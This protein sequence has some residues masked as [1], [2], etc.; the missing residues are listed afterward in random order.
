[1]KKVILVVT[2]LVG[3][4]ITSITSQAALEWTL[5][6]CKQHWG[7]PIDKHQISGAGRMAYLFA[8]KGYQIAVYFRNS[9]VCRVAY[10]RD[11]ALDPATIDGLLSSNAPEATWS[12]PFKDVAEG[13][14]RFNGQVNGEFCYSAVATPQYLVIWNKKDD[15][16]VRAE[17]EKQDKDL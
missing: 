3:L 1:M 6:E 14:Y 9:K 12:P 15:D 13:T 2:A 17:Q 5:D 8:S 4:L 11:G 7:N 10:S 16:A